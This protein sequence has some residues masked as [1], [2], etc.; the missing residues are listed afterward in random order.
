M[1]ALAEDTLQIRFLPTYAALFQPHRYKVFWGGRG[2]AKSWSF[3]DALLV[4]A[5]QRPLRILCAREIQK[6][7]KQSV[8]H[9]LTSRAKDLGLGEFYS[10]VGN[11]L[12]GE[13]GSVFI[14]E[15]LWRNVD[16][17]KSTEAIDIVWVE[18]AASVSEESW[19]QLIPTIRKPGSEI[20]ASFNPER[21]TDAAYQRFVLHP[22]TNAYIRKVSWRDNPY[23]S[24]EFH[25]DRR[26]LLARDEDE[27]NHVYE[28]EL[29]KIA[30]GA[31]YGKQL[32]AAIHDGR[33]CRIP[34][35]AG[36]PVHTFWDLGRNDLMAIWFMQAVGFERRFIDYFEDRLQ[37][38]D[39]YV[40]YLSSL[41]YVYGTHHLPHDGDHIVLGS[42]NRTRKRI[43]EDLGL[44]DV[45]VLPRIELLQTGI[46]QTRE[47]FSQCYF[48]ETKTER[49]IDCL[50]NYA[51]KWS[52]TEEA[53]T[54]SV[55]PKW[56]T[57]GADAFRQAA[58]GFN[59]KHG[60]AKV[61]KFASEW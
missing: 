44:K 56:A 60:K 45:V 7:L 24:A 59:P 13:N 2:G 43:L 55:G 8:L 53:W 23:L 35:L 48:E 25:E 31:I 4:L 14:F 47:F 58:Q 1:P 57:N 26:N 9:L 37:D 52:D 15:G 28:G 27:Y 36:E 41:P 49:G 32:R 10:E 61:L 50:G 39:Y 33:I 5:S 54:N 42:N 11:E 16:E 18:E 3:A 22:P 46:D 34:Y 21:K 40:K 20:W 51:Y 19:K 30:E 6:S 17:I 29:R 12:I 38:L